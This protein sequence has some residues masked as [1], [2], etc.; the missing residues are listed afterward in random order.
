MVTSAVPTPGNNPV[1]FPVLDI[2]VRGWVLQQGVDT[3]EYF[4]RKNFPYTLF[5]PALESE[6]AF[7]R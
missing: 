3:S 5:L 1:G 2:F 4:S 6:S 7:Q